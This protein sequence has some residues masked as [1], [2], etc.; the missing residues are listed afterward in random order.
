MQQAGQPHYSLMDIRL[1]LQNTSAGSTF[2][3]WRTRDFAPMGVAVRE[4]HVS[5]KALPQV[6]REGLHLFECNR[7]ALNLQMS[8]VCYWPWWR[9]S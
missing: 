6:I 5:N 3:R 8:V 7:I 1:M 9:S 4:S 2:L